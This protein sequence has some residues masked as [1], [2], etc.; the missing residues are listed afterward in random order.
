MFDVVGVG[1]NSVDQ[2]LIIPGKISALMA[3]GKMRVADRHVFCGGQAA[4]TLSACAALGLKS[5]YLGCFGSDDYGRM[6]R[7]ELERRGVDVRHAV[8]RDAQNA[9]AIIIVD[10]EGRRTVMWDRN[11]RLRLEPEHLH[12]GILA[13]RLVHIDDVDRSA[14]LRVCRMAHE[15]GTPVTSDIEQVNEW[16]EQLISGV[17]YPILEQNVPR[18]LTG[19]TDPERALRKLRRLNANLLCMTRG[20]K[21]AVALEGDRFHIVPAVDVKMVDDT[22][23]GDTFRAGFIYGLLQ[24]WSVPDILRFANATAAVSCTRLGAIPSVP[25]LEEVQALLTATLQS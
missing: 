4:T 20:D 10:G 16:T 9:D 3:S 21:G 5:R 19:E 17:T 13:A 11:E 22:G 12:A 14:A 8:D 24:S 15:A 25:T 7:A 6:M 2:V 1:A 18:Q 23:A